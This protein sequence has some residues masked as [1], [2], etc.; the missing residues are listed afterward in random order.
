[1]GIG[2]V[3]EGKGASY[4]LH[5]LVPT[6]SGGKKEHSLNLREFEEYKG[7]L[8]QCKKLGYKLVINPMCRRCLNLGNDCHG[9]ANHVH[10]DCVSRKVDRGV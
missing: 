8:A 2:V 6:A 5:Y 3:Y 4:E 9:E 10:T 7:A 1:M